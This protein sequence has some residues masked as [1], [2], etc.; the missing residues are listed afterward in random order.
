MHQT[1]VARKI[2][3][4]IVLAARPLQLKEVAAVIAF[5]GEGAETLESKRKLA[6]PRSILRICRSLVSV[7]PSTMVDDNGN[8]VRIEVLG[9]AHQ[10]VK[11]FLV[12]KEV[13]PSTISEYHVTTS[14]NREIAET[15]LVYI[16]TITSA[17]I[18]DD[19]FEDTF[20]L[21]QYASRY[22]MD[23][24][25]RVPSEEEASKLDILIDQLLEGPHLKMWIWMYDP[26][27]PWR[28]SKNTQKSKSHLCTP[29]YYASRLGLLHT[30]NRLLES[31]KGAQ[32]IN[33]VCDGLGT[34]LQAAAYQGHES[35][36]LALLEK[37]ASR[38]IRCG[39]FG[40]A[41]QAAKFGRHAKIVEILQDP[42]SPSDLTSQDL[43]ELKDHIDFKPDEKVPFEW[44][45][46]IGH[47]TSGSVD[48]IRLRADGRF[49]V[50]KTIEIPNEK[51]KALFR[52]E[53]KIM[54]KLHHKHIVDVVGSWT[55]GG[56]SSIIMSPVADRNLSRYLDE[57]N[58]TQHR[59]AETADVLI[60]WLGCL[61]EGLRYIHSQ[62][63]KHKDVKPQNILIHGDNVLFTDFGLSH[64]FTGSQSMTIGETSRTIQYSAPEVNNAEGKNRSADIFSLGC[65]F[66]EM[67]TVLCQRTVD[68]FKTTFVTEKNST[69][70]GSNHGKVLVWLDELSVSLQKSNRPYFQ[71]QKLGEILRDIVKNML[72]LDPRNRPAAGILARTI[73]GSLLDGTDLKVPVKC[74]SL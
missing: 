9:L 23:H 48:K 20:P 57:C 73:V 4:W 2:M 61:A 31:P 67:I 39:H 24:T 65:V 58:N 6:D 1:P 38:E 52:D 59:S 27:T 30:V 3:Q 56:Y 44:V 69:F 37:G 36:V 42:V 63:I 5:M 62:E 12:P 33:T 11:D 70:H 34:P 50:R 35:I 53:V 71:K 74:C 14:A 32:A 21:Q 55:H 19:D 13:L 64:D 49:C 47:G 40:T 66:A 15:C 7:V 72:A 51:H 25:L 29:L 60:R 18:I 54:L 26:D 28:Q 22:W 17:D 41:L 45:S 46:F 43:V 8:Q 68:D 16:L 10:S